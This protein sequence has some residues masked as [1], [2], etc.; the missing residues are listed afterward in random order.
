MTEKTSPMTE[1]TDDQLNGVTGGS[2]LG[3]L[4]A[5]FGGKGAAVLGGGGIAAAAAGWLLG[6]GVEAVAGK[7]YPGTASIPDVGPAPKGSRSVAVIGSG[8]NK[9]YLYKTPDGEFVYATP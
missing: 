8:K 9:K 7:L 6:K 1:L 2:L 5:A 4:T 3:G